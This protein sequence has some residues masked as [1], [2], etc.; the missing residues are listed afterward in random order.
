MKRDPV[1]QIDLAVAIL[2][3][4]GVV[5]FPT[6]TVYGLGAA[7]DNPAAI[8]RIFQ[9]K[10]RPLSQPMPLLLADPVQAETV[11]F[12]I[13]DLAWE[14]MAEFWP[15]ALTL[16]LKKAAWVPDVLTAGSPNVAQ[17]VPDYAITISLIEGVG[18]P[19]VGTSANLH[20]RPAPSTA[21]EVRQQ[22]EGKVDFIL[23]GGRVPG[24]ESTI[25]DL[26]VIPPR[27][28]RE[29]AVSRAEIEKHLI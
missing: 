28:L 18:V 8:R 6:D 16:V 4:G 2:K 15:G 23:D 3:N 22:L 20:G 27:I 13:P 29:G 19:L 12:D 24:V 17:R 25:I 26:T 21:D 1:V 5:A 14:F 7:V 11:A 10:N 9:I